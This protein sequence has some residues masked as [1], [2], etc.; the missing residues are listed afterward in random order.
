MLTH[1]YCI[2]T[3]SYTHYIL[4]SYLY[5]ELANNNIRFRTG[6]TND[7][8]W[9]SRNFLDVVDGQYFPRWGKYKIANT[10]NIYH[11]FSLGGDGKAST[12]NVHYKTYQ[13][14][15]KILSAT[16]VCL[17][18]VQFGSEPMTLRSSVYCNKMLPLRRKMR[19]EERHLVL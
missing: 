18:R 6:I 15:N 4:F 10:K 13:F 3:V 19:K 8:L 2:F 14:P 5:R 12:R 17:Y 7:L 9:L 16:S 1:P 11:S